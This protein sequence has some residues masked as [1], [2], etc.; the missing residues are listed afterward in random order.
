M[1]DPRADAAEGVARPGPLAIADE[2]ET[3]PVPE[4]R[5]EDRWITEARQV[6]G[7]IAAFGWETTWK[8]DK[9]VPDDAWPIDI[10]ANGLRAAA[11]HATPGPSPETLRSA[12]AA[13]RL[14]GWHLAAASDDAGAA[15]A[16][17]AW[18]KVDDAL[19]LLDAEPR[20]TG[21]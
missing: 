12:N 11:T 5:I 17:A 19:R 20:E 1:T 13:M 15:E 7:T 14:H 18:E 10:I 21:P 4:P 16:F 9:P 8:H 2:G 6:Y 3:V